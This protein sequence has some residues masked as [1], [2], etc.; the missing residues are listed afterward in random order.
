MNIILTENEV[1]ILCCA[2][3]DGSIHKNGLANLLHNDGKNE[4]DV[5][6]NIYKQEAKKYDKLRLKLFGYLES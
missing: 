3:K 5:L 2:L 6:I 1:E 4:G